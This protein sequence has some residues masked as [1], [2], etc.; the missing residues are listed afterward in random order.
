MEDERPGSMRAPSI[1]KAAILAGTNLFQGLQEAVRNRVASYSVIKAFP[2]GKAIFSKGDDG[3]AL[4]V[5]S[6]GVVQM[7]VPSLEGKSAVYSHIG[8]GEVFGEIALLDGSP[9]TTDAVAFTAC[10]LIVIERRDFLQAL[11]DHPEIAM[12]IIELLCS[13][14][15]RTTTQVEDLMFLDLK[16]RVAKTL[17]IM[18]SGSMQELAITQ[19]DLSQIVGMSREMVNRQLQVWDRDGWISLGRRRIGVLKPDCLEQLLA[20]G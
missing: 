18:S 10:T 15:R 5:V 6:D 3:S 17:L 19:S 8:A 1:D 12:R 2:R 4:F 11:H 13:R 7:S 20:E 14:I 16:R 9:R